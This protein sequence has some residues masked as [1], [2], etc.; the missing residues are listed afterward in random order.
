MT[1]LIRL[2]YVAVLW[3]TVITIFLPRSLSARSRVEELVDFMSLEQLMSLEANSTSF[4]DTPIEKTPGSLYIIPEK[5][6]DFSYGVSLADYLAYYVPGAHISEFYNKGPLYSARGISG[7][8]NSTALFMLDSESLNTSSGMSSNLNLPLLGYADRV[9]VLNGPC[10]L[11]HGSGSVNGFVNII[12]KNGKNN[13][14]A[15]VSIESGLEDGQV[16]METGHGLSDHGFGDFYIYAGAVQ[17]NTLD[18]PAKAADAFTEPSFRTS[19]NWRKDK[20]SLT[21]FVGQEEFQSGLT[22]PHIDIDGGYPTVEMD[23][24]AL[25]PKFQSDITDTEDVTISLPLKYFKESHEYSD[26]DQESS[27]DKELQVTAK[28]LFR[29]TRVDDHR[30]AVGGSATF[31]RRENENRQYKFSNPSTGQEAGTTPADISLDL[32]WV[33]LSAFMEDT[34]QLTNRLSL[35]SGIRF[36][37]VKAQDFKMSVDD[38]TEFEVDFKGDYDEVFTPRIGMTYE[39][40]PLSILKFMYQQGYNYPD[41]AGRIAASSGNDISTEKIQ[42]FELGYHQ[43]LARSKGE[44]NLNA[45]YNIFK[46]TALKGKEDDETTA[47]EPVIVDRFA[48]IGFEASILFHPF[49][50]TR[51]EASYAYSRPYDLDGD[52]LTGTLTNSAGNQWIIYPAHT[53]K[54]NLSRSF[55]KDRLDI[56]LGCLYNNN[57]STPGDSKSQASSYEDVF[58]HHRFVVN[59]AARYRLVKN[60][61]LTMRAN[62]ILDNGVPATGYN[63]YWGYRDKNISFNRP[64]VYAGLDWKF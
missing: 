11:I 31:Y 41:Y 64:S 4:F 54:L 2:T 38:D 42:S 57:V 59:A 27:V 30:V 48:A 29:S 55:F 17:S 37:S 52:A 35:F 6:L 28:I 44:F 25:M 49:Q 3:L 60:L 43:S 24:Y 19:V 7:G 26:P 1:K 18:H 50:N 14:G 21:A 12:H 13:P 47:P 10:S 40:A 33:A 15:F 51:A 63:Y 62:N 45:Y 56:T 36:D 53:V 34:I 5:V 39:F 58:D 9:E 8:S 23:S 20:F 61:S 46:D 16:R 22:A 32:S